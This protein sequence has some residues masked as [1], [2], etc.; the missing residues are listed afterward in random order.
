MPALRQS[1]SQAAGF[2]CP[3]EQ[4]A[5]ARSLFAQWL[6]ATPMQLGP[7]CSFLSSQKRVLS[8]PDGY[9]F[10]PDPAR[11]VERLRG[12]NQ[13]GDLLG[14]LL[15]LW[16]LAQ[17]HASRGE[18]QRAGH[19][20]N[21]A[22]AVALVHRLS[23]LFREM[24]LAE[25]ERLEALLT[26]Q[27][28]GRPPLWKPCEGYVSAYRQRLHLVRIEARRMLKSVPANAEPSKNQKTEPAKHKTTEAKSKSPSTDQETQPLLSLIDQPHPTNNAPVQLSTSAAPASTTSGNDQA[29]T[30]A[31]SIREK[32]RAEEKPFP[33]EFAGMSVLAPH[34]IQKFLTLQY[35]EIIREI[36]EDC[37]RIHSQEAPTSYALIALGNLASDDVSLYSSFDCVLLIGQESEPILAYFEAI[38]ELFRMKIINMGETEFN[39]LSGLSSSASH[40]AQNHLTVI[41]AGFHLSSQNNPHPFPF[42]ITPE[43]LSTYLTQPISEKV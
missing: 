5:D 38:V 6:C 29:E 8:L 39:L 34:L 22:H 25:M 36:F 10:D 7:V 35:R 17:R 4:L 3:P 30:A 12:A 14:V 43:K 41:N 28:L 16:L 23:P 18:H 13:T 26:A 2:Q 40:D 37:M 27:L 19:F 1:P 15:A 33:E 32:M 11:L 24:L 42:L 9:A 31:H 20:L 21:A